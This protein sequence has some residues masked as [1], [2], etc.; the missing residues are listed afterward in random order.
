[1]RVDIHCHVVPP[2]CRTLMGRTPQGREVG[3][4]IDGAGTV[5]ELTY[6]DGH[7]S[8]AAPPGQLWDIERRLRDMDAAGVDVQ[9]LS[10]PP[11][12]FFY[13]LD[14]ETGAAYARRLNDGIAAV[15]REYPRRFAGL[16]TVP[17]QDTA[18]AIAELE[19]A[20]DDL[21]LRGLEVQ[22]HVAGEN[23]DAP[24][25]FPFWERVA[26]RGLPVFIHPHNVLGQD[27][28]RAY[29]LTNLIGNPV[30]TAVAAASLV[31]GGVLARLPELRIILAHG[32]GATAALCGRWQHGWHARP[33]PK[34]ALPHPPMAD[35]RRFFFDTLTHSPEMLALVVR[36]FGAEHVLLG[37]DYP[38]DMGDTTPVVTV[39][40]LGLPEPQQE[41]I[42]GGTAARL[43]GL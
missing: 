12:L 22:S 41:V 3:V 8:S 19:R 39:R 28:L 18:A 1:M 14:A 34:R 40:A 26:A 42:L 31:F 4:R 5:A 21:G 23:L 9:A 10:V 24:R 43:L 6:V 29:Y 13:E 33:E 30:D 35:V 17:L 32:G 11:F 25:L 2:G 7:P 36:Q 16:A 20:A 37:T 27:R 38:F 15:V